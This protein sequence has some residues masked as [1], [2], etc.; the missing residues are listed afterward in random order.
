MIALATRQSLPHEFYQMENIVVDP[1]HAMP[2][3]FLEAA[4]KGS[5]EPDF[6]LGRS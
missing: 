3:N 4:K 6:R 5:D 1:D 2:I